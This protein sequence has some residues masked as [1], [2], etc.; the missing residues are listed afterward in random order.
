MGDVDPYVAERYEISRRLGKGAYGIV[1]K[2]SDKANRKIVAVKKIY[3]A[4]RNRTDAQRTVREIWYLQE[5]HNHPNIITLLEVVKAKND[6]DIYLIFDFMETDLHQMIKKGTLKEDWK[7]GF[8]IFQL[9]SALSY[10]HS[11]NVIHRDIKPSN[12]L[13]NHRCELKLARALV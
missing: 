4:F 9:L 1:W 2:A 6:K 3:D 8:I 7:H 5:F 12:I 11:S 10:I 13:M